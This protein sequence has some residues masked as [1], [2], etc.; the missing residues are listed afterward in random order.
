M[1]E[2]LYVCHFSNG[3]IKVG[4]STDPTSRIANHADR[5]A[6]VGIELVEHHIVECIGHS[7]PAESDLIGICAGLATKRNKSEWFE[8]L[9]FLDVCEIA[10]ASAIKHPPVDVVIKPKTSK[11]KAIEML[12]GTPRKAADAMGY[13]SIQAVYMWPDE[14]PVSI[15]Q[16]VMWI[17]SR[18]TAP[19]KP[20]HVPA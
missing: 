20:D 7:A 9:D 5:V 14:L 12:G 8:G 4:R 1:A 3:H 18:T 19:A 13:T 10:N 11:Q 17:A 15:L 6:C 16:R 2:Y